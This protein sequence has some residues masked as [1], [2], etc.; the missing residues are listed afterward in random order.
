[1]LAAKVVAIEEIKNEPKKFSLSST[2][3]SFV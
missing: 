3:S 1:M 2:S